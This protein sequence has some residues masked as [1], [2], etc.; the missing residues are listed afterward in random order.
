VVD[1]GGVQGNPRTAG[2]AARRAAAHCLAD[3]E[4]NLPAAERKTALQD[5]ERAKLIVVKRPDCK[6]EVVTLCVV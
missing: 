6:T 5:L 1:A 3:Q 2:E 4:V